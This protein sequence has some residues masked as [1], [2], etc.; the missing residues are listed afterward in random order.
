MN[1]NNTDQNS[2]SNEEQTSRAQ[3]PKNELNPL[4]EKIVQH[5][6]TTGPR[7]I[8]E[9][10]KEISANYEPVYAAFYSLEKKEMIMPVDKVSYRG[11]DYDAFW[12]AEKGLLVVLLD[13][14]DPDIILEV[15]KETFPK[16]DDISLFAQIVC[17]L[18]ER[19]LRVILSLYPSV[20]LQVG[21]QEVL[22]FLFM[23]SNLSIDELKTLYDIVKGSPR[24]KQMAD[25]TIK[26]AGDRFEELRKM[27]GTKS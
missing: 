6:A 2:S 19:A 24:H 1:K 14:G 9:T 12:L 22:K 8:N 13:G 10:S 3:V 4:E 23:S 17:R 7:N 18:P 27:I 15:V 20:S 26:K 11:R 16:L 21:I 5:L 25:E